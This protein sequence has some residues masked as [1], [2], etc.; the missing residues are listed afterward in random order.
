MSK[1]VGIGSATAP[2][3]LTG[4][5]FTSSTGVN[6]GGTMP[7]NGA[8][9]LT[10]SGTGPVAIPAGY[11]NGSGEVAQVNVPAADVLTGTTIAGVAGTMPNQGS[12]TL[13]PGQ[14]IPAG[15]YSGGSVGQSSIKVSTGNITSSS[16]TSSFTDVNGVSRNS[17]AVTVPVPSGAQL[18]VG[19]TVHVA[20]FIA[21]NYA[22]IAFP[23]GY[24]D[25]TN[26]SAVAYAFY[27]GGGPI[28][29]K[30]A[31]ALQIGTSGI[32]LPIGNFGGT[33]M[34]YAVHY[35]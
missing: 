19:V 26:L 29:F 10:P 24:A 6:Q 30:L 28:G 12:P 9:T 1:V 16:S 35:V 2:N 32:V 23:S 15:Y 5:S 25:D 7:N 4:E 34:P 17:Y 3:V 20:G 33:S 18:I 13:Q 14:S 27:S 11:H 22:C 8:V 21:G 31:G